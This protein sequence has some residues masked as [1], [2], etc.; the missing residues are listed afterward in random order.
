[1]KDKSV[2]KWIYTNCGGRLKEG[3]VLVIL[4]AWSALCVTIFA[5]LSQKVMDSA[6][7]GDKEALIRN[8]FYLFLVIISQ[9]LSRVTASLVEAVSQGKAEIHLRTN[10]FSSI[11]RGD[12]ANSVE[13][14]SGDLVISKILS[15]TLN[16]YWVA[17]PESDTVSLIFSPKGVSD[18]RTIPSFAS[19]ST[20]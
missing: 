15:A 16:S 20:Y 4:N 10:M 14:H 18:V 2:F 8:A 13:K 5:L 12:Y 17:T 11:L 6:Q 9:I 7:N 19:S 3:A 1:M